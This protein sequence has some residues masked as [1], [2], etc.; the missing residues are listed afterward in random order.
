MSQHDSYV[1]GRFELS[2]DRPLIMGIVNVT[3]DS[4]SDGGQHASA[5]A[6]IAHAHDLIRQ[7]AHILD[8]GGESTRPGA[9][10]VSV[11][12][13]LVRTLPVLEGLRPTGIPLSIDTLKPEVMKAALDAGADILNDISGFQNKASIQIAANH[14]H[15]GLIAMHM[16]GTPAT[17]QNAPSYTD[18]VDEVR[19]FLVNRATALQHAG[20]QRQRI[21][22]D[23]GLGFGKTVEQNYSLL[24]Q[25]EALT[26]LGMPV[27]VGLSRKSMLGAITGKAVNDRLA[28]SLAGALAAAAR[29]ASV[30][31][32]H[33]VGATTDA[34]AV[35]QAVQKHS[36]EST[37]V[38]NT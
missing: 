32:V 16:Q 34:L 14:G 4:F 20:V 8:I 33:D 13:E 38:N 6:A 31:R 19:T 15:C 17:M 24:A 30:L 23:P 5:D 7:G 9:P 12:E 28:A 26:D 1:C 35:W 37:H 25:L 2:L 29:G 27:L 36:I 21:M 22:L 11:A 10:S 18:V 3:P